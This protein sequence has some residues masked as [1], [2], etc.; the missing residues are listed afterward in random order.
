MASNYHFTIN[1]LAAK[2]KKLYIYLG[3]I[4]QLPN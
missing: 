1:L 3:A 4:W 2:G